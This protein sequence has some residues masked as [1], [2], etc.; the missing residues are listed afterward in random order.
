MRQ[1][2]SIVII[3]LSLFG[4]VPHALPQPLEQEAPFVAIAPCRILDTATKS[5][6]N[7]GEEVLRRVDIR[8]TRCGRVVPPY[9]TVYSLRVTTYSRSP[10]GTA[11]PE[12]D[13]IMVPSRVPAPANGIIEFPVPPNA[14]IAV[15]ID[16]Y[17]VAPGTPVNPVSTSGGPAASILT[18]TASR[19]GSPAP[20]SVYPGTAGDIYLDASQLSS[21][22][23][24]M[25]AAAG[26][27]W[28]VARAGTTNS[29]SG[30]AV[31]NPSNTELVRMRGD[32]A[33]QLSSSSFLDGR[34]DFFGS[35]GSYY[36]Y[37]S[38]PGNVIHDVTL[39][40]PRDAE[41][42][43]TSRVIFFNARTAD[44]VGSPPTTKF[45]AFTLGYYGQ[46]DINFDSQIWYH[47]PGYEKYH[48]RAYSASEAKDTF[49][50]RAATNGGANTQ[51]RADMYVSGRIGVGT[52]SPVNPLHISKNLA[53]VNGGDAQGIFA[54]EGPDPKTT[55]IGYDTTNDHGFLQAAQYN[56]T[57]SKPLLLQPRGGNVG[58]GTAS[59]PAARLDVR[60]NTGS[61][62]VARV[63]NTS[64]TGFSGIEYYD[65]DGVMGTYIGTDNANNTT[66]INSVNNF[67]IALLT[68]N[69]E[70]MR[71]A[72]DGN[73]GIGGAPV[74]TA[75]LFVAGAV[76]VNGTLTATS[77]IGATYQDIAEW[78][79][80]TEDMGPGTVV[81]LDPTATNQVKPSFAPYDTAVAGVISEQPG[82]ILGVPSAA[83][84]MVATMGRVKVRVTTINGPIRV[85]DLLVTSG[86]A[87]MAMKSISIEIQGVAIHRPGTIVG[88]ALEPMESGEGEILVLLSLQ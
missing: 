88:K 65:S 47:W 77:V 72:S 60:T 36:G 1:I 4:V 67:P 30:F 45:Q 80:A 86:K 26:T 25:T 76:Q 79:P 87:G 37:V 14:H 18:A 3:L 40:N 73:I 83:K 64:P 78:V 48:F 11:A 27:P 12:E 54:G 6:S 42:G 5:P 57:W 22:G 9:A 49:W 56:V 55:L 82:V 59:A 52:T 20:L 71:V 85:G 15:D 10:R 8:T 29:A 51:T 58:I 32:G 69:V 39:V 66:R 38:I 24:L 2:K 43:N 46:K 81:V 62:A 70:R 33:V 17:H 28:I 21:A 74:A 34:T 31:V 13:P 16:G 19:D 84:E 35:P 50:V 63:M 7:T 75:K 44:E 61:T 23:V 53:L 41:A 68:N